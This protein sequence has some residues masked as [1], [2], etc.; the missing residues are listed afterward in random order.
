MSNFNFCISRFNLSFR[1]LHI[2]RIQTANFSKNFGAASDNWC[3]YIGAL[4]NGCGKTKTLAGSCCATPYS[5]VNYYCY[6]PLT[7]AN[8]KCP[9]TPKTCFLQRFF[10]KKKHDINP[11]AYKKNDR[12]LVFWWENEVTH[13]MLKIF[14]S[15][16]TYNPPPVFSYK[17]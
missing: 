1:V 12:L 4:R 6:I 2:W 13:T 14:S 11:K 9:N 16:I 7:K 5:D 8:W 3:G 17:V 10:T 15:E